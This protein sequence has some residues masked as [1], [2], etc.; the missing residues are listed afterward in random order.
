MRMLRTA[1]C[2]AVRSLSSPALACAVFLGCSLS[3]AAFAPAVPAGSGTPRGMRLR[4]S[5]L[6]MPLRP[7]LGPARH[8]RCARARPGA[9]RAQASHVVMAAGPA[10]VVAGASAAPGPILCAAAGKAQAVDAG[11]QVLVSKVLGYGILVGSLFL[12]VPQLFKILKLRSVAGISRWSRYSEV[13][14]NTSS[15]IY[16]YL[17]HAP[18]STWGE[19]IIVLAQNLIIVSLCWLWDK[20]RVVSASDGET[21]S[22]DALSPGRR[23]E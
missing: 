8:A 18:L 6:Q 23:V 1:P 21:S 4:A 11:L 22:A 20:Q 5:R 10:E 17:I 15:C 9:A 7:A 3:A 13:P 16:H 2:R 14:I 12:Q 19:N